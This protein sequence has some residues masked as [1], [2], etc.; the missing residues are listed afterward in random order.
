MY[1]ERPW[2]RAKL[3]AVRHCLAE[4]DIDALAAAAHGFVGADLAAICDEAAMA[5]LRRVIAARQSLPAVQYPGSKQPHHE[6]QGPSHRGKHKGE[7]LQAG[8]LQAAQDIQTVN[9]ATD[10]HSSQQQSITELKPQAR[11][12]QSTTELKPQ[13]RQQ[14]PDAAQQSAGMPNSLGGEDSLQPASHASHLNLQGLSQDISALQ[15]SETQQVRVCANAEDLSGQGC[16]AVPGEGAAAD[17]AV[18][19]SSAQAGQAETQD[20]RMDLQPDRADPSAGAAG[21]QSSKTEP[22]SEEAQ[23]Q[24]SKTEPQ[25]EEGDLQGG[26]AELQAGKA[27]LLIT[28]ADFRVAETRVRP[29]AMREVALEVP[30]VRWGDVGGLDGVKQRLQEAVQWPHLHPEALAR[31]GAHPPKGTTNPHI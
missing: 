21:L 20:E 14:Q 25:S 1:Q 3:K 17:S 9:Q 7:Q 31:L 15:I 26:K 23:L 2:C 12:Q 16:Q 24:S 29:S 11:Q 18:Q 10:V 19:A 5:A 30:K 8:S 13:A 27:E 22:Q 6:V 4:E 28:L